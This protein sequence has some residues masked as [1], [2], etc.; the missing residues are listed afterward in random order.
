MLSSC[1]S[2]TPLCFYPLPIRALRF[3]A[4]VAGRVETF[5]QTATMKTTEQRFW[6]KV[7]KLGSTP[8]HV[9]S[10]GNCWEW[11][12][13]VTGRNQPRFYSDGKLWIASRF[14]WVIHFGEIP[15][16]ILVCHKC[17]NGKCVR[18]EHIFLGTYKDNSVDCSLKGRIHNCVISWADVEKI[19]NE[20]SN[21]ER[22]VEI[23]SKRNVSVSII[24]KI[25]QGIRRA[26]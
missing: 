3:C 21:G 16:G 17:D 7:N 25:L 19:K 6:E 2:L 22:V 4:T 11:T 15:D 13:A 10:I 20:K 26:H 1:Y 23:A 24:Y 5:L 18:P 9:N 14:S 8:I 12:G